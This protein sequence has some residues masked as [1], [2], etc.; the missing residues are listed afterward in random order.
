MTEGETFVLVKLLPDHGLLIKDGHVYR[1]DGSMTDSWPM[2]GHA[3]ELEHDIE[4]EVSADPGDSN[5]GRWRNR[6]LG[7][8]KT[9]NPWE[10]ATD[11]SH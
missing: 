9:G 7:K 11:D 4:Y 6:F 5:T 10:A 2:I 1:D 8:W 3:L